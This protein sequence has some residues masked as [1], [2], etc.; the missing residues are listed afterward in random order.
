VCCDELQWV[1]E[2][3]SKDD[4]SIGSEQDGFF[5]AL[6]KV[7]RSVLQRV[8]ACCSVLQRE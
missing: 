7:C 1:D 6:N 2:G 8:A 4:A 3:E 5:L